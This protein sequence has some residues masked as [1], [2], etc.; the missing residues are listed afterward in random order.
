MSSYL[1]ATYK[2]RTT[3]VPTSSSPKNTIKPV[4]DRVTVL[5]RLGRAY[6][7]L[8]TQSNPQMA[9]SPKRPGKVNTGSANKPP[10]TIILLGFQSVDNALL[11][12]KTHR[13]PAWQRH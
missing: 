12:G 3:A 1:L 10:I 8:K 11:T 5:I 9:P 2:M 6:G 4:I 7:Y 13:D